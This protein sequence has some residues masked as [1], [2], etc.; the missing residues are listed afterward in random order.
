[1]SRFPLFQCS[2]NICD[3]YYRVLGNMEIITGTIVT[4]SVDLIGWST[5]VDLIRWPTF[6]DLIGWPTLFDLIGWPTFVDLIGWPTFVDLIGWPTF[7]D[8]IG[9][10][11]FVN[12]IGWPPFV[13]LQTLLTSSRHWKHSCHKKTF[14]QPIFCFSLWWITVN[15]LGD[16]SES[17]KR[18]QV[19]PR[20]FFYLLQ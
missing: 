12:L 6:V 15:N 11:T 14:Q 8:L 13:H 19:L 17:N 3:D 4:K 10:P 5:F 2:S 7:F 20:V 16:I 9:W 18:H 1:M